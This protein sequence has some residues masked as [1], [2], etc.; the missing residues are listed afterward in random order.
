MPN[1]PPAPKHT[2]IVGAGVIGICCAYYLVRRGHR[3]TVVEAEG[4][5]GKASRGNAGS[6]APGHE[7]INK[8]GRML[9]ALKWMF[10][11]TSPLYVAPRP[12]LA[13][14]RWLWTFGRYC[15]PAHF[16]K[17]MAILGPLGH[18]SAELFEEL[19]EEDLDCHYTTG[20]Y[21]AV[22]RTTAGFENACRDADILPKLGY[23][24]E[25]FDGP[26]MRDREPALGGDVV[27]GVMYPESSWCDPY[28]FVRQLA[29][30]VRSNGGA[31]LTERA[32]ARLSFEGLRVTGVDT[33]EGH[34]AADTVLLA[35]GSET[36]R[37]L[38]GTQV[39]LPL[40]P[41]KGY[42]RDYP[43]GPGVPVLR[44]PCILGESYVFCT[45]FAGHLRLAGTLEFSGFNSDLRHERL[46]QL[47]R[48]AELYYRDVD[49]PAPASEWVGQRP[50][51]P[52]GLPALGWVGAHPGLAIATGHAMMGLTL[53]PVTGLLM[54]QILLGDEPE[55][56]IDMLRPDRF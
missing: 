25:F 21:F 11:S 54:A 55:L 56:D 17:A 22:L 27:G 20:G 42:H 7:P 44:L 15:N 51:L 30:R 18:R 5:A 43:L 52:D 47:S 13:L 3:V 45:P 14:A 36:P 37:L 26:A 8:P 29:D 10:S 9:Q 31:I 38:E 46:E 23:A 4:V 2:V 6:I 12:D 39:R 34:V 35:A 28:R 49:L 40:Q 48:A 32:A 50:C 53:G 16:E 41:A 24:P 33:L 19:E 1:D